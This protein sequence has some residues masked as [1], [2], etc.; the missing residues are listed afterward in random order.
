MI[1]RF[2]ILDGS[3]TATEIPNPIGWADAVFKFRRD[4]DLHGVFFDYSIPLK[5][6]GMGFAMIKEAY[7][8]DGVEAYLRLL[9]EVQCSTGA[10]FE[11]FY[12]GKLNFTKIAFSEGDFCMVEMVIEDDSCLSMFNNRQDQE[13]ELSSLV[14]LDGQTMEAYEWINKEITLPSKTILKTDKWFYGSTDTG[15]TENATRDSAGIGAQTF[16]PYMWVKPPDTFNELGG[17]NEDFVAGDTD[18]VSDIPAVWITQAIPGVPVP[19]WNFRIKGKANI[20]ITGFLDNVTLDTCGGTDKFK[21]VTVTLL[22]YRLRPADLSNATHTV[23][24]TTFSGCHAS[25]NE[26]VEFDFDGP[27]PSTILTGDLIHLFWKIEVSGTYSKIVPLSDSLITI[28][29]TLADTIE[30]FFEVTLETNYSD[31]PAKVSMV[32]ETLSRITE[33]IT[34]KC[35]RVKSDYFGRPDSEPYESADDGCGALEALTSGLLIRRNETA[36]HKLSFKK[37]FEGLNAIHNIGVGIEADSDRTGYDRLRIE[38]SSYFYDDTVIMSCDKVAEIKRTAITDEH[39]SVFEFGYQKWEAEAYNGLDEFNTSRKYRTSL[40]AIRNTLTKISSL[41][42]SGYAIEVTR[43]Q[44]ANTTKDWRYDNDDFIICLTR[45][46]YQVIVE[47]G[48]ITDPANMID[49]DT[50]YNFRISPNRNALRWLTKVLASYVDPAISG[51]LLFMSGTGNT[52]AEG[53]LEDGCVLESGVLSEQEIDLNM[54][55]LATPQDGAPIYK[56]E[57]WEFEYPLSFTEWQAIRANPLGIIQV[58]YGQMADFFDCYIREIEYKPN[59]GKATFILLP[60][61]PV[62]GFQYLLNEDGTVLLNE[63]G[64]PLQAE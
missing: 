62:V 55:T 52:A 57:S 45:S 61:Y 8:T 40:T 60:K 12:T 49:P 4:K 26:L 47:Q 17:I 23:G 38:Q 39:Y 1:W 32:N 41:I 18:T 64:T 10:D 37:A 34:N 3:Y 53:L 29:F 5:F 21:D 25:L 44:F 7:D 28:N 59:E 16:E 51:S 50:V 27:F 46:G 48:N 42:A 20:S 36:T 13:V 54:D 58:R 43:Q 15:E 63:D 2:S 11:E 24:T 6:V 14:T 22:L 35:L 30:S 56:L 31:T 33:S 9:I 19:V